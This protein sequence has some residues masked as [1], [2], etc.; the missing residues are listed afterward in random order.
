MPEVVFHDNVIE[1]IDRFIA[2]HAP[3]RGGILLGPVGLPVV[4]EFIPD[5]Q[6]ATTGTTYSPS[7]QVGI[8]VEAAT[9]DGQLEVKGIVHSHPG[10]MDHP[11]GGDQISFS[12]WMSRMPWMPFLIAPIVTV[13]RSRGR[14]D[15]KISLPHGELSVFVA[16][17]RT[18]D[19][20][21]LLEANP[22]VLRLERTLAEVGAAFDATPVDRR[23]VYVPLEGH[24]YAAASL[25]DSR[26]ELVTLLLPYT[27][28]IQPPVILA[29]TKRRGLLNR[30]TKSAAVPLIWDLSVTED[31]RLSN[32]LQ[33]RARSESRVAH[34]QTAAHRAVAQENVFV[35][36][37]DVIRDGLR[38]RLDGSVAESVRDATVLVVGLGSG[39]SQTLEILTRSSVEQ[40]V[41][42][43]PDIVEAANLSRSTYDASDIGQPKSAA[44]TRRI[45]AI[46]PGASVVAYNKSLDDFSPEAL[47][48]LVAG[49]DVVVA[50]TDDPDAQYRLNKV[51]WQGGRPAVFAGVYERGAAGEVIFTIPGVTACFH[52]ATA[53]RRGGR[54]GATP[55]NYGTGTLV[56]EPAL[57]A[58]I[59]HVV[60]AS[61]KVLLGLIELSDPSAHSNSA[62]TMVAG[63]AGT[64]RNYLQMSMIADYDYFPQIFSDVAGQHAYQSVWV[65]TR[66]SPNCTIC[67]TNPVPDIEEVPV[68]L[69]ALRPVEDS[70]ADPARGI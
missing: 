67:G 45:K 33:L 44:I 53:G 20:V 23:V 31:H 7:A 39:G 2:S 25:T 58:D 43:D 38:A 29:P 66:S 36:P 4:S 27:Y 17:K 47:A 35:Q 51:A 12:N 11:S 9:Q 18:S 22:R 42:I 28:P 32:A 62:A 48:E 52:C 13:G 1:L 10:S 34:A 40:F 19:R 64:G 16:E 69:N 3:E 46:N 54:R 5:P 30:A 68:D 63:A 65:E 24:L 41:V 49:V 26:G 14:G 55:I 50:A 61:A 70:V 37:S 59:S 21:A 8:D 6:A 15:H 57:G 60:S 56:A